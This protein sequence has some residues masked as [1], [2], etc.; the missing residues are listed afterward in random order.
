MSA[1]INGQHCELLVDSG[2]T[3]NFLS[4]SFANTNA[5]TTR[6]S[7]GH[8]VYADGHTGGRV[9][10]VSKPVRLRIGGHYEPTE[11]TVAELNNGYDRI[12]GMPWLME[13]EPAIKWRRREMTVRLGAQRICLKAMPEER[14]TTRPKISQVTQ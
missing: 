14:K 12:L 13:D 5:L 7:V 3:N 6:E 9:A 8:V 1:Q 4:A 10:R 2:A 11:F